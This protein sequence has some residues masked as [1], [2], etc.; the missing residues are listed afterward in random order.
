MGTEGEG[1]GVDAIDGDGDG[2]GAVA[3]AS[4]WVSRLRA[5]IPTGRWRTLLVVGGLSA[6]VVVPM[7]IAIGVLRDPRWFPLS[8]MAQIELRVRDVG[9]DHPPLLGLGG[10]LQGYGTTGSHPGPLSFFMLAPVFRLLGADGTALLT[11]SIVVSLVAAGLAIWIGYRRGGWRFALAVTV[12][13]GLLIRTY[14]AWRL[15]EAWNPNLPIV[16]WFVFLL[17]VWSV[18]C[19]DLPMLPVAAFAGSYC[20][21]TH[22]PYVGLVIGL[23][24]LTAV[25]L[26]VRWFRRWRGDAAAQRRLLVWGGGTAVLGALLWLPPVIEQINHHPGNIAIIIENF[27]NPYDKKVT[28]GDAFTFW[29]QRLDIRQLFSSTRDTS[30]L[31]PIGSKT[32]GL[33]C[34]GLWAVTAAVAVLR[35]R[36]PALVRLHLTVAAT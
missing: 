5:R 8:D 21:Q 26:V 15:A 3:P 31:D 35:R 22:I 11:S 13:L 18:V 29:A 23:G 32:A 33:V 27:R 12:I 1:V 14:G 25:Y 24:G 10:R 28:F 36:D 19:D 17:A 20:A 30:G 2:D 6:V 16:W 9:F 4:D 7:L 34:V